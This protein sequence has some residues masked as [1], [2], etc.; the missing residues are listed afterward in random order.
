[1]RSVSNRVDGAGRVKVMMAMMIVIKNK[2]SVGHGAQLGVHTLMSIGGFQGCRV[3]EMDRSCGHNRAEKWR[4]EGRS[5]GS[6]SGGL[7]ILPSGITTPQIIT[8]K[9]HQ[10]ATF[11]YIPRLYGQAR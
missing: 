1:V 4:Q 3:I 11:R 6:G 7:G 8:A 9:S 5:G 10:I 2:M